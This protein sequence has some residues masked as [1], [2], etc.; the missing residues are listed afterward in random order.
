MPNDRG[1]YSTT[2]GTLSWK[3]LEE[4]FTALL[5]RGWTYDTGKLESSMHNE[6]DDDDDDDAGEDGD[7]HND[8]DAEADAD[9]MQSCVKE[10]KTTRR[11]EVWLMVLMYKF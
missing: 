3:T 6:D 10:S 7:K 11:M 9:A 5:G 1:R 4:A 8:A 2:D